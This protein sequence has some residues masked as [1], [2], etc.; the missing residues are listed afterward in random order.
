MTIANPQKGR[1]LYR[2]GDGS[3]GTELSLGSLWPNDRTQNTVACRLFGN[4]PSGV[5]Y[6]VGEKQFSAGQRFALKLIA[7]DEEKILFC[8]G[9]RVL[10]ID[11]PPL[12]FTLEICADGTPDCTI[13]SCAVRPLNES[14]MQDVGR[15]PR[16]RSATR[17]RKNGPPHPG[18]DQRAADG[19][20]ERQA[21]S[22]QVGRRRHALD[23]CRRVHDG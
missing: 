7:A 13:Q 10:G 2:I 18:A 3:F 21:L 19:G 15:S 8:N 4:T 16:L 20:R 1:V 11:G 9:K 14:D 12:D 6:W 17:C 5:F 23:S 22:G